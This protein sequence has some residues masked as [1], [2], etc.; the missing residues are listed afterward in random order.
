MSDYAERKRI[1]LEKATKEELIAAIE[2]LTIFGQR[3]KA[4]REI[5]F[6]RVD[7]LL[8]EMQRCRELMVENLQKGASFNSLRHK[9]WTDAYDRF[10]KINNE[11]AKLHGD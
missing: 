1:P 10:Q 7:R 5:Y 4:E 8:A 9:R 6:L 11:L 3:D 2:K